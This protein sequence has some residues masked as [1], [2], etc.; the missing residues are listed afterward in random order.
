M[1]L[2]THSF[3]RATLLKYRSLL[4][5]YLLLITEHY[6]L[7]KFCHFIAPTNLDHTFYTFFST[8]DWLGI[9]TGKYNNDTL[10]CG[11]DMDRF[12]LLV[13]GS[14]IELAF[15]SREHREGEAFFASYYG[16]ETTVQGVYLFL[17]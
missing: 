11:H 5:L 8:S 6:F 2:K 14:R 15:Y 13:S 10:L 12:T 4:S 16:L 7:S 1:F 9:A 3:P 17:R